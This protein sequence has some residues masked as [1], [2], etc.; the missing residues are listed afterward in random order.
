MQTEN[1]SEVKSKPVYP[2]VSLNLNSGLHCFIAEASPSSEMSDLFEQCQ[3]EKALHLLT[4]SGED[5]VSALMQDFPLTGTLYLS[6]TEPFI[7]HVA[8]I[9]RSLGV[10]PDQ[11]RMFKPS[12]SERNLFCCHC[13][14]ITEGATHSPHVCGGCGRLLEVTDH[15]AKAHSAYFSY[16]INAEDSS[17]NPAKQEFSL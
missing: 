9:A 12:T 16:Q 4:E 17:D 14:H 8:E 7:W 13:Y 2:P 11:I 6:G 1:V 5:Q 15:F 3:Q 10:Q